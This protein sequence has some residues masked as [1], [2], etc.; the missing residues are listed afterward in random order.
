MNFVKGFPHKMYLLIFSIY[1]RGSLQSIVEHV[2]TTA[3]LV[4][5]NQYSSTRDFIA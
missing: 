5:H 1:L 4:C 2:G 3:E